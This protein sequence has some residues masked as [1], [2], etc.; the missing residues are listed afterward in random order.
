[1]LL[2][3]LILL[4]VAT[5]LGMLLTPFVTRQ[6]IRVGLTDHPDRHRKTHRSATPLGGG[7]AVYLSTVVVLVVVFL[8]PNPL[9]TYLLPHVFKLGVLALAAAVVVLLGLVDDFVGLR[10]RQKLAGQFLAACI[11]MC[12]TVLIRDVEIF[13]QPVD[14]GMLAIPFSLFWLVGAINAVNLL[15]GID[16][17]AGVVGV[18]LA[19]TIALMATIMSA[20]H[21]AIVAV[22][23]AGS[24]IG[25]LRFNLPPARIFLGDTGSMLIGLVVGW[26]AI[27][28]SLKG[29]GT[30]LL[31]APLA[32]WAIP[33]FD[34][35]AA[36]LRR[37][38]TGRSI[39]A[40]DRGHLH[41]RLLQ[42]LGSNQKVLVW[43]AGACALTS[44]GALFS[45]FLKNDLIALVS[46]AAII[47][48]FIVTDAFGRV[49][50]L[51]LFDRIRGLGLSLLPLTE[52]KRVAPSTTAFRI[53]GSGDWYPLWETLVES[54]QQLDLHELR[55]DVSLPAVQEEFC[56]TWN[57]SSAGGDKRIWQLQ[58]PLVA[59]SLVIG[60][61]TV[62]G[63]CGGAGVGAELEPVFAML[64]RFEEE[65]EHFLARFQSLP[66]AV[67][68]GA[69]S[70]DF[71]EE[72]PLGLPRRAK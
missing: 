69:P 8:V 50:F 70:A 20:P 57:G 11:L 4:L 38:L 44:A 21:V 64:E 32:I 47:S 61:M 3:L 22:V 63:R 43:V 29:P 36:V 67:S 45:V 23:F 66:V 6:A 58:I 28:G 25:F 55:L 33:I 35:A 19:S 18:I 49:E 7:L 24:L 56:A 2:E 17:L 26:L 31:G 30:V 39:Y 41:H 9:R 72:R 34:S 48:I 37:K 12:G 14:L 13:G 1:M 68:A 15:D 51:L 54:A 40:T 71:A 60:Q 27:Q 10:G 53:Q 16:G 62:M 52:K 5:G 46:C 59:D 42:R 65:F